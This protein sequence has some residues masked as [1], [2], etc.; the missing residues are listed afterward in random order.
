MEEQSNWP[1]HAAFM[2]GLVDAGFVILGGPLGDEHR[3]V[4]AV[5]ATS[6][7]AVRATLAHAVERDPSPGQHDRR[8]DD[9]ARR[10]ARL[11]R[12]QEV[13]LR[14]ASMMVACRVLG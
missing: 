14:H 1:A 9:P 12:A 10:A 6:E 3:V 2:D 11:G 13:D 4:H 8:V 5:E 7:E